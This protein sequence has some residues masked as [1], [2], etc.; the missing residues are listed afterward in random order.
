MYYDPQVIAGIEISGLV[1]GLLKQ[2]F[3]HLQEP[4]EDKC[5]REVLEDHGIP[6]L[7]AETRQDFFRAWMALRTCLVIRQMIPFFRERNNL[8][9]QENQRELK[10]LSKIT[11]LGLP[12]L[13]I[14]LI[15]ILIVARE[16]QQIQDISAV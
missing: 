12:S 4:P 1:L 10:T 11:E 13:D 5:L 14:K 8:G 16:N 15:K 6:I 7:L 9:H 2:E 3:L